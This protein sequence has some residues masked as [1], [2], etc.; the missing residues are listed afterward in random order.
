MK[1][2]L[3]VAIAAD[4]SALQMRNA[5]IS[6]SNSNGST[7]L[8]AFRAPQIF[9]SL[10]ARL[11]LSG[12]NDSL[13]IDQEFDTRLVNI[14]P[15]YMTLQA[16][17]RLT[18][19][20]KIVVQCDE[21][22][23]LRGNVSRVL[24][25]GFVAQIS[26]GDSRRKELADKI[27][28]YEKIKNFDAPERRTHKRVMPKKPQSRLIFQNGRILDCN[29]IDVSISGVAVCAD[30]RPEIG[31]PLA[32]GKLVG[33]VVRHLDNGFAVQFLSLQDFEDLEDGLMPP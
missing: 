20:E 13:G 7:D 3:L 12:A 26:A 21:F 29:V 25:N 4:E 14:S 33:R 22:G 11:Y 5:N 6:V 15:F 1:L 23:K 2:L 17:V 18:L 9:V 30:I 28:W 24:Q 31:T 32:V 10:P 8:E 19:A 27:E 16:K